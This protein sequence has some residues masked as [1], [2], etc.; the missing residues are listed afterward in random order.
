VVVPLVLHF[1]EREQPKGT[2]M[3][4]NYKPETLAR[5]KELQA[6]ARELVIQMETLKNMIGEPGVI[7]VDIQKVLQ[8][9]RAEYTDVINNINRI[10]KGAIETSR[11]QEKMKNR[12]NEKMVQLLHKR[13]GGK[14]FD[15]LK[16]EA[17]EEIR[18]EDM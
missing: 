10:K 15:R 9:T 6:K 8:E 5:K 16:A 2:T 1:L 17:L 3:R 11:T 4:V 12:F 18:L 14:A 7:R 13:V